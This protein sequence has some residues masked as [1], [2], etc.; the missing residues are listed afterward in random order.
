M[1]GFVM[2]P[3]LIFLLLSLPSLSSLLFLSSS[4]LS[5]LLSPLSLSFLLSSPLISSPPHHLSRL[6]AVAPQL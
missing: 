4:P 2:K 6:L 3:L 1:V 5:S